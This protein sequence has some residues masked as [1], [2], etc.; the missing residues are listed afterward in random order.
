MRWLMSILGLLFVGHCFVKMARSPDVLECVEE[1]ETSVASEVLSRTQGADRYS[2]EQ[3]GMSRLMYDNEEDALSLVLKEIAGLT[4]KR[5]QAVPELSLAIDFAATV[6]GAASSISKPGAGVWDL[7][8]RASIPFEF[9]EDT[10]SALGDLISP[11]RSNGQGARGSGSG[12]LQPATGA[13]TVVELALA[14]QHR[15]D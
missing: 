11:C 10:G 2:D 12:C 13:S 5:A 8:E 7:V 1:I 15:A 3:L 4:G 6:A 9:F 14:R